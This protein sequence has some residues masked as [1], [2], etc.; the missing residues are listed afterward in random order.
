MVVEYDGTQSL[1]DSVVRFTAEWCGPC[2]AFAPLFDSI[3]D[4]SDEQFVVV[5]ID[6]HIDVARDYKVMSSPAVVDH[7]EKVMDYMEWARE[8]L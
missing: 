6:E 5:D 2:K 8:R 4:K 1:Q 3:A 7:G